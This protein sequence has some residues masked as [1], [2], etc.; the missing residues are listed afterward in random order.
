MK[1]KSIYKRE[2][3][4]KNTLRVDDEGFVETKK[5]KRQRKVNHIEGLGVVLYI[6]NSKSVW[7]KTLHIAKY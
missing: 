6:Y 4:V 5:Q 7:F 3:H 1:N 2:I